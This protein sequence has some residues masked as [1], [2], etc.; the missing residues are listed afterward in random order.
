M[1]ETHELH[2]WKAQQLPGDPEPANLILRFDEEVPDP[3]L[4][5]GDRPGDFA[6][7]AYHG[8]AAEVVDALATHLPGGLFD[9][10]F[11]EMC[12]R[13]ASVLSVPLTLAEARRPEP[14]REL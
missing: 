8:K 13:K 4:W 2:S 1:T 9:A 12:R 5:Q 6:R 7:G 14:P 11:T 10:M 3:D